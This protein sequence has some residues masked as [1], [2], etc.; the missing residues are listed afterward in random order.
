MA[1]FPNGTSAMLYEEMYC[2]HCRHRKP[3][4]EGGC[5]VMFAH[6]AHNYEA[7][8]DDANQSLASVLNLLIPQD[9]ITTKECAL[10][11]PW[12]D[13]RCTKTADMFGT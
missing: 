9:G 3:D 11:I 10:F 4:S 7:V 1:Y 6:L 8:G 2:Q 12:D 5:P 13:A